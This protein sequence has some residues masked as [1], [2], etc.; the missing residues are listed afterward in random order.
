[1]HADPEGRSRPAAGV[2]SLSSDICRLRACAEAKPDLRSQMPGCPGREPAAVI[3]FPA[4]STI[5]IP[6]HL[7]KAVATHSSVLA[8]RIPETG[9][10]DGL[11]SMETRLKRLSSS[12]SRSSSS[13][14]QMC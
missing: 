10:P 2:A 3:S 1:M 13:V 6:A 12:S 7:E 8:W 9:E 11:P 4:V 5:T 14:Y